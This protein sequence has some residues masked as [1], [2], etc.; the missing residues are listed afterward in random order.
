MNIVHRISRCASSVAGL[1]VRGVKALFVFDLQDRF[2]FGGLACIGYGVSA[3]YPPAAWIVVGVALFWL[4][5][6]S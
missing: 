5:V 3:I 2:V 6:R 4:G 1:I